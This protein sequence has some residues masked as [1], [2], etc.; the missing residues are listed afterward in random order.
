M[1][2]PLADAIIVCYGV[3][4]VLPQCVEAL[5]AD[6]AV[7]R[8]ILVDNGNTCG[9]LSTLR[10]SLGDRVVVAGNGA[11]IGFGAGVNLGA[12][13]S[14][15]PCLLIVNPDCVVQPLAVST[16]VH[17]MESHAGLSAAAGLLLN[18]DGTEQEGGRRTQ[19]TLTHAIARR[20][21]LHRLPVVGRS[22]DFNQSRSAVPIAPVEVEAVS[23]AFMLVTREAFDR[24]QGFDELFFLHFEDLDLCRRLREEAGPILFTPLAVAVHTKGESSAGVP[25]FVIWH[26]H[27]SFML[28]RWKYA[29]TVS[30]WLTLGLSGIGAA[31]SLALA[32]VVVVTRSTLSRLK[33]G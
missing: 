25:L 32:T 6:P 27:R 10:L 15:S 17:A 23:G 1:T 14:A 7:A 28:Y 4:S 22:L 30:D 29:R 21:R 33:P 12:R 9:Q 24:V 18:P 26:K 5:L 3:S 20:L 2:L 11:N 8:V 16:L 13:T 31:V 19:P